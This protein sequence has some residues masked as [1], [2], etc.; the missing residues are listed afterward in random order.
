[1]TGIYRAPLSYH[2]QKQKS[3]CPLYSANK[4]NEKDLSNLFQGELAQ[5]SRQE[6][7]SA[8]GH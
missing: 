3:Q 5:D 1:M 2:N 7:N 8:L 6:N 4:D